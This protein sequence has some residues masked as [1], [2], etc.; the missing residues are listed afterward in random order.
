M[1]ETISIV[2]V[3]VRQQRTVQT[4]ATLERV[5]PSFAVSNDA[6]PLGWSQNWSQPLATAA[7]HSGISTFRASP[8]CLG[9]RSFPSKQLNRVRSAPCVFNNLG[10]LLSL[11]R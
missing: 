5:L 8:A 7:N 1:F 11:E 10:S 9:R 3:R 4:P 2:V 6:S